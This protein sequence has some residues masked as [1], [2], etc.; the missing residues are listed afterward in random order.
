MWVRMWASAGASKSSFKRVGYE[1]VGSDVMLALT[2]N[3][4]ENRVGQVAAPAESWEVSTPEKALHTGHVLY[5]RIHVHVSYN[6]FMLFLG[7]RLKG[8]VA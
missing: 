6:L 3:K 2:N 8:P 1:R 5:W 4:L 7:E